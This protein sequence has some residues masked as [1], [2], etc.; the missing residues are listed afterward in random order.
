M[1]DQRR[2]NPASLLVIFKQLLRYRRAHCVQQ[3][4]IRSYSHFE[5]SYRVTPES[6]SQ[7]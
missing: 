1:N 2:S 4:R 3:F 5:L 6:P 7:W